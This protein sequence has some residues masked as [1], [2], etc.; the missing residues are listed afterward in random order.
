MKTSRLLGALLISLTKR[1]WGGDLTQKKTRTDISGTPDLGT[2]CGCVGV[3]TH[4]TRPLPGPPK[5]VASLID[6]Y[7]QSPYTNSFDNI[8]SNR[9][10]PPLPLPPHNNA[11]FV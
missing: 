4:H 2:G 6:E 3:P 8:I 5:C 7:G 1:T 10:R 9:P 11:C